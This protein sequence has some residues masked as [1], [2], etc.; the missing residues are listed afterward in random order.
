MIR[1]GIA[2][3]LLCHIAVGTFCFDKDIQSNSWDHNPCGAHPEHNSTN[4][5]DGGNVKK[6]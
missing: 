1:P 5:A 2:G 6:L 3:K 4:N